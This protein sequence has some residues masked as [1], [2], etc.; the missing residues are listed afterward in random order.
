VEVC[1]V[2]LLEQV[3]LTIE[4]S[5]ANNTPTTTTVPEYKIYDIDW[6]AYKFQ[7]PENLS[8]MT[9]TLSAKIKVISTG[10]YQDLTAS[11][12]FTFER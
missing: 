12:R 1:P 8:S 11:R 7:V 9:V 4:S 2:N 5:D 3:Q 6:S 10:E